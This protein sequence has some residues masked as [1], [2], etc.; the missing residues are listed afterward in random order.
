M[1]WLL[2]LLIPLL[3]AL[4]GCGGAPHA[5]RVTSVPVPDL[6]SV[7]S[8]AFWADGSGPSERDAI[9][10]ARRAVSER[11]GS[12]ITSRG[13]HIESETNGK[14]Q[15]RTERATRTRTRFDHVELIRTLG[16]VRSPGSKIWSA[17]AE[18]DPDLTRAYYERELDTVRGALTDL[19]PTLRAAIRA[20][21]PTVLLRADATPDLLL[22]RRR[23]AQRMLKLVGVQ[24][25]AEPA[26]EALELA[27]KARRVK[28][29]FVIG[30]RIKG[31]AP[32][33]LQQAALNEI[34]KLLTARGCRVTTGRPDNGETLI[35]GP[36]ELSVRD[37]FEEGLDWRYLGLVLE[38]RRAADGA[39]FFRF[40]GTPDLAHGGGRGAAKAE[41]SA[42]RNLAR[43]LPERARSTFEG[44]AC[45]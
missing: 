5:R 30:L 15:S 7:P 44:L 2:T 29:R 9:N 20:Q 36:I 17:R 32:R 19:A 38:L 18:L 3:T 25:P 42:A 45:R 24:P 4:P 11:I 28:R 12:S 31:R 16:T 6:P 33:R 41:E 21:D 14:G 43:L 23:R 22:T 27:A 8:E 1:K 39:V 13:E 40:D 26:A 10:D 35:D 37:H 34:S